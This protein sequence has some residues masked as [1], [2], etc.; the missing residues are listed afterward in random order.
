MA[1]TNRGIIRLL[2]MAFRQTYAGGTL[3]TNLYIAL[4]T[5]D[6]TPDVNTN[7]FSELTEITEGNGYT[8]GGYAL[9]FG[10][11]DFDVLTEDDINDLGFIQ[12]KDVMW[13]A[14]GGPIPLSGSD[15]MYV[16]MT[17]DD[18]IQ[19]NREV[20]A[21]WS[22]GS[23]RSALVGQYFTLQDLEIRGTQA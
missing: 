13:L 7:V 9:S 12:V 8:A 2:E 1:L 17:N 19:D 20:L 18:A 4:C 15:A 16:I 10:A 22:L 5:A 21:Y 23:E 3:P 14:D 11:T 6:D